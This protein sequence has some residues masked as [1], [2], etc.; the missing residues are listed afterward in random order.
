MAFYLFFSFVAFLVYVQAAYYFYRTMPAS[1]SGRHLVIVTSLLALLSIAL[2]LKQSSGNVQAVYLI[3]RFALTLW[4]LF[5]VLFI[6]LLFRLC[7]KCS[8]WVIKVVR[9]VLLPAG[10]W[11]ILFYQLEPSAIKVFSKGSHGLWYASEGTF[12]FWMWASRAYY[13]FAIVM[14]SYLLWERRKKAGDHLTNKQHIHFLLLNSTVITFGIAVVLT[15][16]MLPLSGARSFPLVLHLIALPVVA[17]LQYQIRYFDARSLVWAELSGLFV[18][19]VSQFV[20]FLD[21]DARIYSVNQFTAD[22]LLYRRGELI[23]RKS[24]DLFIEGQLLRGLF[25]R[26]ANNESIKAV[27]CSMLTRKG[28][29]IPVKLTLV[30]LHDNF[31]NIVGFILVGLDFRQKLALRDQ[32]R[33]RR[34]I[35]MELNALTDNLE[36]RVD[37]RNKELKEAKKELALEVIKLEKASNKIRKDL[38]LKEELIREIH[39]RVK[40]NIQ[41]IISLI[42]MSGSMAGAS[43]LT[44][45]QLAGLAQRVR[46]ISIVHEYMYD[47]PLIG[48]INFGRFITK[49]TNELGARRPLDGNV[50]FKLRIADDNLSIDKAIPCGML[51]YELLRNALTHAFTGELLKSRPVFTHSVILVTFSRMGEEYVLNVRDNGVGMELDQS[52]NPVKHGIGLHLVDI[53]VKHYLMGE[54]S[55]HVDKGSRMVIRFKDEPNQNTQKP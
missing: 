12:P 24:E 17:V 16:I 25:D 49:V 43:S 7:E 50:Y 10:L 13:T 8:V 32:A 3:D 41:V 30:K 14:V 53:L 37:K 31:R 4:V 20:M 2:F 22:T 5:P 51:I 44:G 29:A 35:E 15:D 48:K 38:R 9:Y 52:G 39:H 6:Y 45:R 47:S 23:N 34:R 28:E 54:I 55:Y 27:G 40:N 1:E 26:A 19:R 42:N 21:K 33:E 18:H 46:D 11:L 36:Y